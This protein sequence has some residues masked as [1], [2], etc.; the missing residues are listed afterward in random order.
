MLYQLSYGHRH[1]RQLLS[2]RGAVYTPINELLSPLSFKNFFTSSVR[3]RPVV[4]FTLPFGSLDLSGESHSLVVH[5]LW[6]LGVA[7]S[8]P[9]SPTRF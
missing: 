2:R 4:V 8:N 5:E 1:H 3:N 7:G 9:A 6:E